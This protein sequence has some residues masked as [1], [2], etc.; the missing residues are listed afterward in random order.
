VTKIDA[1]GVDAPHICRLCTRPGCVSACPVDALYQDELTGVI[2]LKDDVCIGCADCVEGCPFGVV[3]LH[4]ETGLPL[5][6]DLC[7]GKPA[8]VARCAPGALIFTDKDANAR[9]KREK[10][11]KAPP[12]RK[13]GRTQ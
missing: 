11:S 8:C 2:H 12:P 7:D 10:L 9:A 13:R 4:M 5:M 1:T 6:C 3:T